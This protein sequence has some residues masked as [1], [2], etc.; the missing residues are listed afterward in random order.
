MNLH[1]LVV[2][3]NNFPGS[4]SDLA[5]C[6]N[7]ARDISNLLSPNKSSTST[8]IDKLPF[9]HCANS[10][11]TLIDAQAK[12]TPAIEAVGTL[13]SKLDDG[14]WGVLWFS[15][16][17]TFVDETQR[18]E[19]LV[20]QDFGLWTDTQIVRLLSKRNP[21]S[22][23]MIGT[24]ACHTGTKP[25]GASF[26]KSRF[27]ASTNFPQGERP[28]QLFGTRG[29]VER[30]L[31]PGALDNVIHFAGCQAHEVCYDTQFN[32]RPNGAFTYYLL[33]A[34]G[35]L[36]PG[37]TFG[38]LYRKVCMMLPTKQYPQAPSLNAKPAM[39]ALPIPS[40]KG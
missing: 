18:H 16:H 9:F 17:G 33:K 40:R 21:K 38:D 19:A 7:D 1:G 32:G 39:I 27:L 20:F 15:Q 23:L 11:V 6:I 3:I 34:M 28:D 35:Q 5:G 12:R 2:G 36:K 31:P 4:G 29:K 8:A 25:R 13:L 37:A 10:L 14:D 24:D 26:D 22:F 30:L